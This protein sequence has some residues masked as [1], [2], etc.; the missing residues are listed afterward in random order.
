MDR[1]LARR[2][3]LAA[4][5]IG[6][7]A[8]VAMHGPALGINLPIVTATVLAAAWLF[9][10]PGRAPD[11]LDAWLPVS[12]LILAAFVAVRADPFVSL[13][14]VAGAAAFTGA[15]AAAFSGLVVTRRSATAVMAMGVWVLHGVMVSSARVLRAGRPAESDGR[16]QPPAWFGP[17][18]RGLIL[19]VPLA[20]IFAVLF[21]SADPIFSRG[22]EDVMN[23]RIDL[24]DLPGRLIFVLAIAWLTGGV[25]GIAATGLPEL[26]R[27][28]LGAAVRSGSLARER[29]VGTTEAL[30]VLL[31]ID[32]SWGCSW[33]C[34]SPTCSAGSTRWPPRA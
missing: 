26:E 27:S 12:A 21:A 3:L 17:V 13:L 4:L 25:L 16:G 1:S 14:D 15:S 34:R 7:L 31:A 28:S 20:L 30:V 32:L 19:A 18:G 2:I 29:L 9:R 6:L 33:R 24:G 5:A 11:P 23:F 10:R 22:F 8:E